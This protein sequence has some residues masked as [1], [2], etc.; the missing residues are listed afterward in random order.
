MIKEVFEEIKEEARTGKINLIENV[1][2][3][4][5]IYPLYIKFNIV[6]NNE[7]E[8]I[9]NLHIKNIESFYIKLQKYLYLVSEIYNIKLDRNSTKEIIARL[10]SNISNED[11]NDIE[12]FLDKY[13]SFLINSNLSNTEKIKFVNE[14]VGYLN[15]KIE[16]QSINQETPYCFKSKFIKD[17]MEYNLPRISFGIKDNV[18]YIYAIQNKDKNIVNDSNVDYMTDVKN[19]IRTINKSITKYRNVTPS[20]VVSIANFINYIY[21]FDITKFKVVSNLPIRINNR[22]V[23]TQ[24]RI[25]SKSFELSKE[26]LFNFKEVML[27]SK[28]R[29][30]F[31]AT[32]G[33]LNNFYRLKIHFYECMNIIPNSVDNNIFFEIDKLITKTTFLNDIVKSNEDMIKY[34]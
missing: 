6:D 3:K 29:N 24:L 32:E 13:I 33:L 5:I 11:M 31:Q 2:D 28:I 26:E 4:E 1:Y 23:T 17:N 22:E 18:C 15:S 27:K 7:I 25:E 19:S 34:K 8:N 9:P 12:L 16:L 10:F 30:N 14:E 21:S 20:F